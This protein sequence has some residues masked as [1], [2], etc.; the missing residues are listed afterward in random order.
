MLLVLLLLLLLL[1]LVPPASVDQIIVVVVIV[2]IVLTANR[3][4]LAL[5]VRSIGVKVLAWGRQPNTEAHRGAQRNRC[6]QSNLYRR[7]GTDSHRVP[8]T[9]TTTTTS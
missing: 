3:V 2:L 4:R 9:E 8:A 7:C 5:R 1:L 6:S